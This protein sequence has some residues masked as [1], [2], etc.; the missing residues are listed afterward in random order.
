M[1]DDDT[2]HDH[3]DAGR[4]SGERRVADEP[5]D[6]AERREGERRSGRDRRAMPRH[7]AR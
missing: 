1:H 4:R 2:T 6:H 5:I 7:Y 3:A